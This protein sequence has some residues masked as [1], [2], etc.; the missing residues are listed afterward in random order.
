MSESAFRELR[1]A[2]GY[3]LE[4]LA[5]ILDVDR[6][7]VSYWDRSRW[8]PSWRPMPRLAQVFGIDPVEAVRLLWNESVGDRCPCGCSGEKVF[9]NRDRA[10]HLYIHLPCK[11]CGKARTFRVAQGHIE[12]C[13]RCSYASRKVKRIKLTCKGYQAYGKKE[14]ANRCP[15]ERAFLPGQVK[16]LREVDPERR[17]YQCGWCDWRAS[18]MIRASKKQLRTI[19]AEAKPNENFPRIRYASDLTEVRKQLANTYFK[20]RQPKHPGGS[21]GRPYRVSPEAAYARWWRR[22]NFVGPVRGLCG[23]CGNILLSYKKNR[24][25]RFHQSCLLAYQRVHGMQSCPPERP[26]T[27]RPVSLESLQRHFAWTVQNK[28]LDDTYGK[29]AKNDDAGKSTVV[30]GIEFVMT[31]L[32]ELEMIPEGFH[33]LISRLRASRKTG[34]PARIDLAVRVSHRKKT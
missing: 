32:P 23:V 9:P 8:R 12:L 18:R 34:K 28:I 25:M 13:R 10:K 33:D 3:T 5:Q 31:H 4:G 21:V 7:T 2:A 1:L 14:H 30:H 16:K 27:H 6:N 29:I 24:P 26:P 20:N 17:E 19:W 22:K 15:K 11:K